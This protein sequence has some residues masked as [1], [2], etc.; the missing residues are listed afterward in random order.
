MDIPEEVKLQESNADYVV[1]PT[2][3]AGDLIIF[4]EALVH[5]TRAW[6]ADHE[7]R[8]LLYKYSPGHSS[9]SQTYYSPEDYPNATEQQLRIMSAPSVGSS[10][11]S[12]QAE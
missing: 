9:Y 10:P 5:G 11:N 8:A 1:Q 12:I 7:R 6:T 2:A 4:T 3:E